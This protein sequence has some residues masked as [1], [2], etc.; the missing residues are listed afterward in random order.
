MLGNVR[1][2]LEHFA[3]R[4]CPIILAYHHVADVAVDP[5]ELA[6]APALFAEQIDA[7]CQVRRVVALDELRA[8]PVRL[9]DKPLAAITF[10][11]GYLNVATTARPILER[12]DCL[13]TVFLATGAIG[14]QREFWWDELSRIL[15]ESAIPDCLEVTI[16]D[17]DHIWDV[18]PNPSRKHLERRLYAIWN[19][20]V[21]LDEA[22]REGVI[23]TLAAAAG[24]GLEPRAAHRI[25]AAGDV[26]GL[27]ESAIVIG[28]HSVTH[29]FLPALDAVQQ[30]SEINDSRHACEILTGRA[31]SSFAYPF[32]S[33]SAASPNIVREAGFSLA[34]TLDFGVVRS[35]TDPL[36]LPRLAVRNWDG[37]SLLRALW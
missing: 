31:P 28:A 35:T 19:L 6:V 26:H 11:D 3:G 30:A 33:Y 15:L 5:W 32:G 14:S 36:L 9:Q 12:H 34:V 13:G 4:A 1:R 24:V 27:R 10:D 7:L 25:M 8:S 37:E 29:P 2:R 23:R 21:P 17:K 16:A 22:E 20:L 18:G